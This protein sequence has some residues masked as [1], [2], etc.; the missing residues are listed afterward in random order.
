MKKDV[1]VTIRVTVEDLPDE[2]RKTLAAE[3][4]EG[5]ASTLP[6]VSDLDAGEFGVL[7]PELLE[8]EVGNDLLF[9][10]S[11]VYAC[12]SAAKFVSAEWVVNT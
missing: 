10:G 9:E 1:L 3:M 2:V 4:D 6:N 12:V 5:D 8:S 7:I 11:D